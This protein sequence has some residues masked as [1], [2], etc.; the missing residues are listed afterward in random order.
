MGDEI[1]ELCFSGGHYQSLY[2]II[3]ALI[4]IKEENLY[5]LSN[6]DRFIGT[7]SGSILC[8]LLV[9]NYSLDSIIEII[10]KLPT[11]K[12]FDIKSKNFIYLFDELGI[13]DTNIFIKI[14]YVLLEDKGY[15]RSIT[16]KELFEKTN[17]DIS[18]TTYCLNS[19]NIKVLNHIFTPDLE[20]AKAVGMSI[21]IPLICKP[22]R[23]KNELYIDPGLIC[24]FPIDFVKTTNYLGFTLDDKKLYDESITFLSLLKNLYFSVQSEIQTLKTQEYDDKKV[25]ILSSELLINVSFVVSQCDID[26]FVQNGKESFKKIFNSRLI[27]NNQ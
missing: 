11:E 26:S 2:T 8:F 20:V 7:S 25:Y 5:N 19:K 22:V 27:H 14:F 23:Y 10:K 15:D 4:I 13:F 24:N 18:L 1:K 21:C 3:G 9:L 6:V 12:I 17:K 16:F